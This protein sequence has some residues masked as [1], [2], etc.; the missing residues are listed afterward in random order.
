MHSY[1]YLT[2]MCCLAFA[3]KQVIGSNRG[4][5][6]SGILADFQESPG[7]PISIS[8]TPFFVSL[9]I[10]VG[11][12]WQGSQWMSDMD[13]IPTLSTGIARMIC[14]PVENVVPLQPGNTPA[15]WR[16]P[17]GAATDAAGWL[18]DFV[19]LTTPGGI[20]AA[21]ITQALQHGFASPTMY[22][23]AL[24]PL[25][26][27]LSRSVDL[28]VHGD[29]VV[30]SLVS[31]SPVNVLGGPLLSVL[32][33]VPPYSVA[34]PL[35]WSELPPEAVGESINEATTQS[36]ADTIA[37]AVGA[38]VGSAVLVAGVVFCIFAVRL[39]RKA[40]STQRRLSLVMARV[41]GS[42][43]TQSDPTTI[44]SINLDNIRNAANTSVPI[45][46]N[47]IALELHS[48]EAP[49]AIQ[50]ND[51]MPFSPPLATRD[52]DV[53]HDHQQS[54][55][56]IKVL[57]GTTSLANTEIFQL[58]P[59]TSGVFMCAANPVASPNTPMCDGSTT[60]E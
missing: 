8:L 10:G 48:L 43:S 37:G 21:G 25:A 47:E 15:T 29:F 23:A 56:C 40:G 45:M 13:F 24:G 50:S 33:S 18:V 35:P 6:K 5:E 36:E 3:E 9:S 60:T 16:N 57:S 44:H 41:S 14:I 42:T 26:L 38:A 54:S 28:Q 7:G 22:M 30:L 2:A 20:S 4:I 27:R 49:A 11:V 55:M 39:V 19:L 46:P 17:S 59:S 31:P 32:M 34:S 51:V 12:P 58:S 1:F 52:A 53:D